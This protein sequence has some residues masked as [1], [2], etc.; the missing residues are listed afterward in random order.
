MLAQNI[1]TYSVRGNLKFGFYNYIHL[2]LVSAF[3]SLGIYMQINK[4]YTYS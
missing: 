2:D 1:F 4:T 3:N